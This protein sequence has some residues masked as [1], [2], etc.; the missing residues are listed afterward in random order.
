MPSAIHS[1]PRHIS[2]VRCRCGPLIRAAPE[3][4]AIDLTG[5]THS[6]PA[7]CR[8]VLTNRTTQV[9]LP[10]SQ[11]RST[12]HILS[13]GS[14]TPVA[15]SGNQAA[16]TSLPAGLQ[17][18]PIADVQFADKSPPVRCA[19]RGGSASAPAQDGKGR[20]RSRIAAPAAVPLPA[21]KASRPTPEKFFAVFRKLPPKAIRNSVPGRTKP[22][23]SQDLRR[24]ACGIRRP[25]PPLG[26][27]KGV[28][29]RAFAAPGAAP[30][31]ARALS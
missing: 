8:L 17:F 4:V 9:Y 25:L 23:H 30:V 2:S 26:Q 19:A 5:R 28:R 31:A 27:G 3:K 12:H 13:P 10:T 16:A 6:G 22:E 7:H 11:H 14:D 1:Q 15:P 18:P 29:L 21:R 24:R 20:R